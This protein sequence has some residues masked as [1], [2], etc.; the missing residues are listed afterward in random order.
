MKKNLLKLIVVV[1]FILVAGHTLGNLAFMNPIVFV[2]ILTLITVIATINAVVCGV[3][4]P[5][6]LL[7][8][9]R[10]V[11]DGEFSLLNF[12]KNLK[13]KRKIK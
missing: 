10:Q 13:N 1:L 12:L 9:V 8:R 4:I 2:V 5:H 7:M 11:R 6:A 3:M